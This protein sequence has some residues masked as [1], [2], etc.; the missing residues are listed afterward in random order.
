MITVTRKRKNQSFVDLK[1]RLTKNS[2]DSV[3]AER[4]GNVFK[5][6]MLPESIGMAKLKE[7]EEGSDIWVHGFIN[8]ERMT[9]SVTYIRNVRR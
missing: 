4:C 5:L 1:M 2:G 6:D 3:Y 9:I 8:L 7:I